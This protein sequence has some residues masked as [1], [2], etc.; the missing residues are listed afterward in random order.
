MYDE[1]DEYGDFGEPPSP[2]MMLLGAGAAVLAV[3]GLTRL[4]TAQTSANLEL[5][6]LF[7]GDTKPGLN[8][9]KAIGKKLVAIMG[10]KDCPGAPTVNSIVKRTG[11]FPT[12]LDGGGPGMRVVYMINANFAGDFDDQNAFLKKI[13][14]DCI[15]EQLKAIPGIGGRIEGIR[16]KRIS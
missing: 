11:P 3:L 1:Y 13:A 10:K 15:F 14:A 4:A 9:L 6:V 7:G 16:A 5:S 8:N 12:E 2:F